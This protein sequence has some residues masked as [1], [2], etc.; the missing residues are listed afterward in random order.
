[1]AR[2]HSSKESYPGQLSTHWQRVVIIVISVGSFQHTQED[3]L[4]VVVTQ[5]RREL[6]YK[7]TVSK[8]SLF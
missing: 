4:Q 3:M 7:Y 1:M 8:K 2:E 6:F 5:V